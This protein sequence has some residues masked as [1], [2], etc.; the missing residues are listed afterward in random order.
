M[1]QTTE[2]PV[3][4]S[5]KKQENF[6]SPKHSYRLCSRTKHTERV[7][8]DLSP[9]EKRRGRE[10]AEIN[11]EWRPIYTHPHVHLVCYLSSEKTFNPS[12]APRQFIVHTRG[13]I[14]TEYLRGN[15][16]KTTATSLPSTTRR[17]LAAPFRPVLYTYNKVQ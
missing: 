15:S 1:C 10:A 14:T 8:R 9:T 2:E 17:L 11:N 16:K 6:S 13:S 3:F 5:K 12:A 7:R 4:N